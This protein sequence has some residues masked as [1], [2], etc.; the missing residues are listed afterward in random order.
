[1]NE[2]YGK[3]AALLGDR[4]EVK[5]P[6][7]AIGGSGDGWTRYATISR[8]ALGLTV[9]IYGVTVAHIVP[10]GVEKLRTAGHFTPSTRAALA[11]AITGH[12][13][14]NGVVTMRTPGSKGGTPGPWRAECL[15]DGRT[16]EVGADWTPVYVEVD[17]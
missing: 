7:G 16:V 2:A 1:M 10:A 17:A 4:D 8:V 6:L 3:L 5:V 14:S 11:L 12:P 15:V 13:Y 9:S